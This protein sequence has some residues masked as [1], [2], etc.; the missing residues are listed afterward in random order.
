MVLAYLLAPNKWRAMRLTVLSRSFA[1]HFRKP[2]S[3]WTP[4]QEPTPADPPNTAVFEPPSSEQLRTFTIPTP[5]ML[6]PEALAKVVAKQDWSLANRIHDEL[7]EVGRTVPPDFV[8][9]AA[10]LN[11]VHTT[12]DVQSFTKWVRLIPKVDAPRVPTPWDFGKYKFDQLLRSLHTMAAAGKPAL[13]FHFGMI[14]AENGSTNFVRARVLSFFIKHAAGKA[15][16]VEYISS[17]RTA[18]LPPEE[19]LAEYAS[20]TPTPLVNWEGGSNPSASIITNIEQAI[21]NHEFAQADAL[22]DEALDLGVDIPFSDTWITAAESFFTPGGVQDFKK[23]FSLQ[24]FYSLCKKLFWAPVVSMPVAIPFLEICAAKGYI[25]I[26]VRR[27]DVLRY[28]E[29]DVAL[30][31]YHNI[32]NHVQA[33]MSSVTSFKL[34]F[35][36]PQAV[37]RRIYFRAMRLFQFFPNIE[38]EEFLP[39]EVAPKPYKP[40]PPHKPAHILTE[41]AKDDPE[42]TGFADDLINIQDPT[43]PTDDVVYFPDLAETLRYLHRLATTRMAPHP[44][45]L[46]NFYE[47]YLQTGRTRGLDLLR[48]KYFRTNYPSATQLMFLEMVYYF[49]RNDYTQVLN[50]YLAN[51][52]V[53]GLPRILLSQSVPHPTPASR[54]HRPIPSRGK[55]WAHDKAN[56]LVWQC[57]SGRAN[58]IGRVEDLYMNLLRNC[59]REPEPEELFPPKDSPG[60]DVVIPFAPKVH[61]HAFHRFLTRLMSHQGAARGVNILK[62]MAQAG[63]NPEIAEFT[64][65]AGF[66]AKTDDERLAFLLLDQ[67]EATMPAS[68]SAST[69]APAEDRAPPR[70]KSIEELP[71]ARSRWAD[72]IAKDEDEWGDESDDFWSALGPASKADESP[73]MTLPLDEG[74]FVVDESTSPSYYRPPDYPS[75][76][77]P[78]EEDEEESSPFIQESALDRDD[79]FILY[80]HVM[81]GFLIRRNF[82]ALVEV[83]SRFRQRFDY[84]IGQSVFFDTLYKDWEMVERDSFMKY[85][86]RALL[87]K[88]TLGAP[89]PKNS[90]TRYLPD[91]TPRKLLLS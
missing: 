83:H 59:R 65:V 25:H 72:E 28:A 68:Y 61:P 1:D 74:N 6:Q 58:H 33:Y 80:M 47:R 39:S 91:E 53:V 77:T 86:R 67:I 32:Q 35:L 63:V 34:G 12:Q 55:L 82:P 57:L 9:A 22:L 70:F 43:Q 54:M 62:D 48:T 7:L 2:P 76:P 36:T 78:A 87:K 88:T 38:P 31:T 16:P 89:P 50:T 23:W 19:D 66:A 21:H 10:A 11:I 37:Y 17:L 3:S 60:I 27:M 52:Y 81:R 15:C 26:V 40:P 85:P 4:H 69:T 90:R 14:M 5:S 24:R 75:P 79:Y 42:I 71:P 20:F 46:M 8:Y 64:I 18:L 49:R 73:A 41:L 44:W 45:T 51:F 29:N 56:A 13:L 30:N 84:Q